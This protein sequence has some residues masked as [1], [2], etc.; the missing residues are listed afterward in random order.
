MR[1]IRVTT[2]L[3]EVKVLAD[4]LFEKIFYNLIDNAPDTG[5]WP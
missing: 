5:D 4:P 3:Y 2:E 1:N